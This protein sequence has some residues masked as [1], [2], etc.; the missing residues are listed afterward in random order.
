MIRAKL[1]Q[2][3]IYFDKKIITNFIFDKTIDGKYILLKRINKNKN[4]RILFLY[5]V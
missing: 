4:E 5:F 1:E 3:E 2:Y